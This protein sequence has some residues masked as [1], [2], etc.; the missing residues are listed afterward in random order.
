MG[1]SNPASLPLG[2]AKDPGSARANLCPT[3]PLGQLNA[4]LPFPPARLWSLKNQKP[5]DGGQPHRLPLADQSAVSPLLRA[6]QTPQKRM[7]IG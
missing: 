4:P 7:L 2:G 1:V 5:C 3:S 6:G